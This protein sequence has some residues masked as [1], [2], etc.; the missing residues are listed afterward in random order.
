VSDCFYLLDFATRQLWSGRSQIAANRSNYREDVALHLHLFSR[1]MRAIRIIKQKQN[2]N[3]A[4]T[5]SKKPDE[6]STRKIE[7]TVKSWIEES[8]QHRRN[9]PRTL[10]A[11]G[12]LILIASTVV[13][14]QSSSDIKVTIATT[15]GFLGPADA[16]QSW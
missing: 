7:N 8:Q 10:S 2:A 15:D 16:I 13:M 6:P 9:L 11:L 3:E 1:I 4:T 12:V 5:E 14:G